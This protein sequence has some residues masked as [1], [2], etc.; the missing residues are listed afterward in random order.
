[1]FCVLLTFCL[2]IFVELANW[3]ASSNLLCTN[4]TL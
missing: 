3:T 4:L 1:L 2:Y